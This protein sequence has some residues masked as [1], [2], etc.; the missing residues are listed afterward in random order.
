VATTPDSSP[1][2]PVR[3]SANESAPATVSE[4]SL[5]EMR[6][7]AMRSSRNAVAEKPATSV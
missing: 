5:G 7:E 2:K 6:P 1:E 4:I 3:P